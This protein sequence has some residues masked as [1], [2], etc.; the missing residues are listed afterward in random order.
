MG[1]RLLA[2][3]RGSYTI[4][5]S[6]IIP[7]I[8]LFLITLVFFA[9][10]LYQKLVLL[11]AVVYTAKQR[12]ATWN[13]SYM[14]LEDG[15]GA[16]KNRD[17][18]Y[19]RLSDFQ[20][21]DLVGKKLTDAVNFARQK[22][23]YG[24]FQV[25]AAPG[26]Q[27]ISAGYS[28]RVFIKR[29]VSIGVSQDIIMPATWL[30]HV[31]PDHVTARAEADVTEPVELIRNVDLAERLFRPGQKVYATSANDGTGTVRVFHA[32]PNCRHISHIKPAN[33]IEFNSAAEAN[34]EGYY[35][36]LDC[37]KNISARYNGK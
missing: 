12:A 28:N 21:D 30:E 33:L 34:R 18:L 2:D 10:Y 35:M 1:K 23:K 37:A 11:D 6:I 8:M 9:M 5:A 36:C 27:S 24:V 26:G 7:V 13:N 16:G 19:W 17:G 25:R 22:L 3:A 32:D 15:A 14:G 20:G 4:E 31:F 29:T